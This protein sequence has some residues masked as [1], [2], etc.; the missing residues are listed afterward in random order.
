MSEFIFYELIHAPRQ[1]FKVLKVLQMNLSF[2]YQ[3]ETGLFMDLSRSRQGWCDMQRKELIDTMITT[4]LLQR[5]VDFI[6][7]FHQYRLTLIYLSITIHA[8]FSSSNF[9]THT[10]VDR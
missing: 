7:G 3:E 10:F 4:G 9:L 2:S 1:S 6:G 8:I 5:T